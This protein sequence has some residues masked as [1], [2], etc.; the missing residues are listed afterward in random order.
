MSVEDIPPSFPN[1]QPVV[2]HKRW[3]CLF[4]SVTLHGQVTPANSSTMTTA[5]YMEQL[6]EESPLASMPFQSLLQR[7]KAAQ[8][9]RCFRVAFACF[10]RH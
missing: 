6:K 8:A 7:T 10:E 4:S 3:S 2:L 5:D 1:N 9:F